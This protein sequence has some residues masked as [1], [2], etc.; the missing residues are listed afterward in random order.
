MNKDHFAKGHHNKAFDEIKSLGVVCSLE[1]E[2]WLKDCSHF[3]SEISFVVYPQN[4]SELEAVVKVLNR[5]KTSFYAVSTG[6]NWGYGTAL[7]VQSCEVL[8]HLGRMNQIK[9]FNKDLGTVDIEPGVTQKQLFEYLEKNQLN[10]FVPTTGAGPAVSILANALERGFGVAPIED[11]ARAIVSLKAVLPTGDTYQSYF[12]SL[13]SE[14]ARCYHWGVGPSLD[15]LF[16]QSNFGIVTEATIELVQKPETTCLFFFSIKDEVDFKKAVKAM[17]VLKKEIPHGVGTLK[18]LSSQQR[19]NTIGKASW[20]TRIL[21]PQTLWTGFGVLHTRKKLKSDLKKEICK[22]LKQNGLRQIRF[23]EESQL[24]LLLRF[25]KNNT[26][27]ALKGLMDL[28]LGVPSSIGMKMIYPTENLEGFHNKNPALD[29]KGLIWFSP[30][31]P[32]QGESVLKMHEV[33]KATL[34]QNGFEKIPITFT[35]LTDRCMAAVVPITYDPDKNLKEAH[36]LYLNLLKNCQAQGFYP[37]RLPIGFMKEALAVQEP[38]YAQII[39][40]IKMAF[41][42]LDLYAKGRYLS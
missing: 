5:N 9:N 16:A 23:V 36:Q 25:T 30:I 41:D 38:E 22:V 31:C 35:T 24:R 42:P 17:R 27:L 40:R 6:K 29:G 15:S 4:H 26:V 8:I 1:T 20:F 37:Y 34:I 7:P 11:H 12:R 14:L 39:R 28:A 33:L 21:Q 32:L 13:D 2:A 3:K 19:N 10:F 18:I